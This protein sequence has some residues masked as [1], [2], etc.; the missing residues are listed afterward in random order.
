MEVGGLQDIAAQIP[1]L[2]MGNIKNK[3]ILDLC[4]APGGKTAQMLKGAFVTALEISKERS[5]KLSNNIK[6][7]GL[8]KNLVVEVKDLVSFQAESNYDIVL[9]DAPCSG[10]GTFRK[11]PDV[12]WIKNKSNV[13]KSF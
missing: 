13:N 10:T 11:N 7:I 8:S 12:V 6:R 4:A 9:L 5:E 1:V 2:L 3:N